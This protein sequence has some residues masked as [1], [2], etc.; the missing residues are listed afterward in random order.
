VGKTALIGQ[1][2]A[3]APGFR[4]LHA[5]GVESEASLGF[6]VLADICRPLLGYW[7]GSPG[8]RRRRCKAR[9]RWAR[10]CWPT[11]SPHSRGC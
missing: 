6:A 4:V 5:V 10:R 3:S 1:V 7:G 11:V 9:W 8:R 2:C